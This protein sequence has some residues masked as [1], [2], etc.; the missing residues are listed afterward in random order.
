[1]EGFEIIERSCVH[2]AVEMSSFRPT[3]NWVEGLGV[4]W[5]ERNECDGS[6]MCGWQVAAEDGGGGVECGVDGDERAF[7]LNRFG[8]AHLES[9]IN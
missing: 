5:G 4:R 2:V 3:E 9:W 7:G 1:M 8:I 6:D